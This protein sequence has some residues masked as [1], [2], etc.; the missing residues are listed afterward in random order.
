MWTGREE[1]ML[2]ASPNDLG[3]FSSI[4]LGTLGFFLAFFPQ[5]FSFF[6]AKD[7]DETEQEP[8]GGK[9]GSAEEDSQPALPTV[10]G[11]GFRVLIREQLIAPG[12]PGVVLDFGK[13]EIGRPQTERVVVTNLEETPVVYSL[14]CSFT[15]M[16]GYR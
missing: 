10:E 8:G 1:H 2:S 15:A 11:E 12:P 6:I 5:I 4:L 16:A 9:K 13:V 14:N 3:P 7:S